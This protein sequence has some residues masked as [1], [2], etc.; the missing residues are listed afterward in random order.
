MKTA[1]TIHLEVASWAIYGNY[2]DFHVGQVSRFGMVFCAD[3]LQVTASREKALVH[4]SESRY[5]ICG[6]VAYSRRSVWVVDFGI[7]AFQKREAPRGIK[8]GS[9]VEGEIDLAV[10]LLYDTGDM[11]RWFE[12]PAL[13]YEWRIQRICLKSPPSCGQ[14]P[15]QPRNERKGDLI[16]VER[17]DVDQGGGGNWIL[18]CERIDR[19]TG[20]PDPAGGL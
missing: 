19:E 8:K 16:K 2:D 11:H 12:M 17:T 9:W 5:R 7:V 18:E 10:A 1:Q 13:Q 14:T 15:C 4:L 3:V 6:E 20:H